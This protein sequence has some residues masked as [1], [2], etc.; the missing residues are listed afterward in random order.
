MGKPLKIMEFQVSRFKLS[1]PVSRRRPSV[2][3][4]VRALRCLAPGWLNDGTRR[5]GRA[6]PPLIAT[7]DSIPTA[8][9]P[10]SRSTGTPAMNLLRSHGSL[11]SGGIGT[12]FRPTPG[13]VGVRWRRRLQ[14][15]RY[16]PQVD[17]AGCKQPAAASAQLRRS[18]SHAAR[19]HPER[20]GGDTLRGFVGSALAIAAETWTF[21]A[22]IPPPTPASPNRLTGEI[23]QSLTHRNRPLSQRG[24][25]ARSPPVSPPH[26]QPGAPAPSG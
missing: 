16:L 14:L 5:L 18:P 8:E 1:G 6:Q 3:D 2:G 10:Q 4:V 12:A 21:G 23:P 15:V 13:R 24:S 22:P 20:S 11:P 17:R 9:I 26:P 19:A 7:A 25:P